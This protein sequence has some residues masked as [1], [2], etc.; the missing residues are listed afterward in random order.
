MT[1]IAWLSENA[2]QAF[3]PTFDDHGC[4]LYLEPAEIGCGLRLEPA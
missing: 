3:P 1:F 2:L 4:G